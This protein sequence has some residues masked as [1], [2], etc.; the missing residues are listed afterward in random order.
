[1]GL[2]GFIGGKISE[3]KAKTESAYQDGLNY[4][5]DIDSS[6]VYSFDYARRSFKNNQRAKGMGYC[7]ALVQLGK[8]DNISDS[9]LTQTYDR[10]NS[11]DSD[12]LRLCMRNILISKGLIVNEDGKYLKQW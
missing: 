12:F 9:T 2:F 4:S 8:S 7:N 5:T 6:F 3:E 11:S 10:Q 1:M